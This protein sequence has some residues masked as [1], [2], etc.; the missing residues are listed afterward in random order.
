MNLRIAVVLYLGL[1][2]CARAQVPVPGSEGKTPLIWAADYASALKQA[3]EQKKPLIIDVSTDWCGW[4]KKM[5]RE[6]FADPAVQ[7]HL[8]NCVLFRLNPETSDANR[9]LAETFE[10]TGYPTL[11]VSNSK[12]EPLAIGGY[13]DAEKFAKFLKGNLAGFKNNPL[14]YAPAQLA[15]EDPLMKAIARLP[16]PDTLPPGTASI[17]LLDQADTK[18]AADATATTVSRTAYYVLDPDQGPTPGVHL[19]YNSS[20]EK[21]KLKS[22]RVLDVHGTGRNANLELAE[23]DHAYSN[24]NVYWD[25]RKITLAM[26]PLKAGQILDIEEERESKPVMPGHHF[27]RWMTSSTIIAMGELTLTF[28][29]KLGFQKQ[30]VRCPTPVI[31]TKNAD[32]TITWKLSTNNLNEPPPEMYSPSLYESWQ[33]Y[34][35]STPLEWN[36]IA[37]WFAGLCQGRDTLTPEAKARV[38]E[39]KKAHADPSAQLQ[40]IMDWVTKDIRYVGVHF[41][42]SS[43][44]PHPVTDTLLNRYGDCKDQSLLVRSLCREAGITANMVLVGTGY[45]H[46]FDANTAS[47]NRFDHCIV[48][49]RVGDKPVYLDPAA[50][51]SKV[52]RLPI[53]CCA[54]QALRINDRT[55]EVITLPPYIPRENDSLNK[56]VVKL[57]PNG[58]AIVTEIR[59]LH[60]PEA[61]ATKLGM[62]RSPP[63]KLRKYLEEA[64]KK[65]GQ[66]LLD[67]SM[68]DPGDESDDFKS[69][70]SFTLPRFASR[71]SEG[72]VFKLGSSNEQGQDWTAALEAPRARPFRFYPSD[73]AVNIY[74]IELPQGAVLKSKPDDLELKVPFMQASRKVAV[75][76]NK[77]TLTESSLLLDAKLPATEAP[78]VL[79]HL[80][81]LQDHRETVFIL[82]VPTAPVAPPSPSP[83]A[84]PSPSKT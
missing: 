84:A 42:Q 33:G 61:R 6:T 28:P 63:E 77:L 44:Q 4:S 5:E 56:T 41:G 79:A 3:G 51:P 83:A 78:N 32:G 76:G 59:E 52:G 49:A 40:A 67:F 20:R 74:E 19:I 9:E 38:A 71:A 1:L 35:F 10:V 70:I 30:S 25:V 22:V 34:E 12:G 64:Y 27:E 37:A 58:S 60:G 48:E 7:E 43:H 69:L 36:Q 17:M 45:G 8:K 21:V 47:V 80:R 31:E 11:I 72:L 18:L 68:T 46:Q 73:A 81:K 66:K 14:G 55:A 50:G 65:Q 82:T 62:R 53:E 39:I 24:Q 2:V 75:D 57:N 13:Q 26:P 23:D 54:V 15:A 29:E 16:K